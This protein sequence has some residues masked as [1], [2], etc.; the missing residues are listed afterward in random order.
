METAYDLTYKKIDAEGSGIERV[1]HLKLV[2]ND[3]TSSCS[4]QCVNNCSCDC[5]R[6]A[7]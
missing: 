6:K 5:D 7:L 4:C 1:H 2:Y 3:L